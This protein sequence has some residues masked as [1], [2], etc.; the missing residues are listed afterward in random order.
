[1][2]LVYNWSKHNPVLQPKPLPIQEVED[3]GAKQRSINEIR[4][5]LEYARE[6][7]GY[8]YDEKF[9]NHLYQISPRPRK[10]PKK[11]VIDALIAEWK[12]WEPFVAVGSFQDFIT[13]EIESIFKIHCTATF[14]SANLNGYIGNKVDVVELPNFLS[15][16]VNINGRL[17]KDG[18]NVDY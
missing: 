6:K 10:L 7:Y 9:L 5:V 13:N 17:K 15:T 4:E 2:S 12:L 11:K 14:K 8:K 1:M 16:T 18:I 3:E